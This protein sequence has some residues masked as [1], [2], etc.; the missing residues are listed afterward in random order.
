MKKFLLQML[1]V[2]LF[3]NFHAH[4]IIVESD[5]LE[6][7]YKHIDQDSIAVFDI[8]D[9]LT[10][11]PLDLGNWLNYQLSEIQKGG[12]SLKKAYEFALPMFFIITNFIKLIPIGNSPKI[13]DHLQDQ[14]I[15]VVGLTSRSIPIVER[16]IEQLEN[17]GIDFSINSLSEHPI[18]LSVTH[19][20]IFCQGI[21][22]SGPNDKGK[23]LFLLFEKIGYQPKKIIFV[24]DLL[25]N[26]KTVEREAQKHN[27]EFVGIRFSLQDEKKTNYSVENLKKNFYNLKIALGMEPLA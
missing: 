6:E 13:I 15:P 8:D 3:S 17:V 5:N 26:I 18:K 19:A 11:M 12:A 25:K 7:V 2:I 14:N 27:I 1:F 16:T 23:M 10:E 24:D 4:A 21:I 22:F 20:G 9:T